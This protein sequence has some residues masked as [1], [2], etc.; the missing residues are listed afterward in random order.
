MK[1][2]ILVLKNKLETDISDEL[3][4]FI[5]WTK[6][7]TPLEVELDQKITDLP[8]KFKDFGVQLKPGVNFWGL[9]RIKDQVRNTGLVTAGEYHCVIFIYQLSQNQPEPSKPLGAWT[10][11]N[12]LNGSVFIETPWR[13]DFDSNDNL[14][15][16]LTHEII[17]G[18][19]RLNWWQGGISKDT[20]DQYDSEFIV[21][22]VDGNRSRNLKE[23]ADDWS[24]IVETSRIGFLMSLILKAINLTKQLLGIKQKE[25]EVLQKQEMKPTIKSIAQAI[26]QYENVNLSLNN[27]GGLRSSPF[28]SGFITQSTT[29]K[30]LATFKTYE[31]GFNALVHQITIVCKGTSPAYNAEAKKA[32]LPNCSE[33]TLA[34]FLGIYAPRYDQNNTD[35]YI[36][37]VESKVN[38]K[39]SVKMKQFI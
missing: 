36:A 23:L 27:P 20:M 28:Q 18:W 29:G 34:Q 38:V 17:H 26:E 13:V 11:P 1:F 16:I 37:F 30:P 21:E 2:K 35:Q 33:L 12:H 22:A 8:L 32:G 15:R 4:K 3:T 14:Y 9:D 31:D 25:L 10:Y 6:K 24:R 19:H 39:R 7:Y 5:A